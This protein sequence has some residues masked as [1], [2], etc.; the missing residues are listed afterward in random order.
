MELEAD[1]QDRPE[2]HYEKACCLEARGLYEESMDE[3]EKAV[4]IDPEYAPALFRLALAYDLRGS[5]EAAIKYYE[6]CR[7]LNPT[8]T[9]ALVNLG[10]L[11]EDTFDY[12][13]AIKCYREVLEI[14]PNHERAGLYLKDALA[15]LNMYYDEDKAKQRDKRAQVLNTPVTDFE[16]SV[17][18]RNCLNKMHIRTL[19]DLVKKTEPELLSFKNFGET[20]LRE[21][22]EMLKQKGLRLGM[23]QELEGELPAALLAAETSSVDAEILER[24]IAQLEFST[25]PRRAL[26]ALSIQT[27]GDLVKLTEQELMTCKNFGQTSLDEVKAKLTELGLKLKSV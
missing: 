25:R 12:K 11:Y 20:S 18:S 3:F 22:K 1:H 7:R 13:H 24:P 14:E 23:A 10:V 19:G 6:Q 17:R 2:Y 4:T 8:Y 15:S 9:H 26:E 16:L 5:D 27:I 21:I